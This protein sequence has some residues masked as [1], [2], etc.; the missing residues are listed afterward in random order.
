MIFEIDDTLVALL[1]I[2]LAHLPISQFACI[3]QIIHNIYLII[4]PNVNILP[5]LIV[6]F[7][8]LD[9]CLPAL[10][11]GVL[12]EQKSEGSDAIQLWARVHAVFYWLKLG[13]S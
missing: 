10:R 4:L 7:H 6:G 11:V 12:G 1:M 3:P 2:A 9:F 5:L 13:T 8:E